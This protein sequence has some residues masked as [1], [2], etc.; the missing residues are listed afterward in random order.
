MSKKLGNG[1]SGFE[2]Q[3][4]NE[5]KSSCESSANILFKKGIKQF[6]NSLFSNLAY[7]EN[8][9]DILIDTSLK[10]INYI[11]DLIDDESIYYLEMN[12]NK[13]LFLAKAATLEFNEEQQKKWKKLCNAYE[14][15]RQKLLITKEYISKMCQIVNN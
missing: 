15:T 10:K 6:F 7:L 2:D 1:K 8:I 4:F 14:E 12:L 5:L 13:I 3:M 11:F 9:I